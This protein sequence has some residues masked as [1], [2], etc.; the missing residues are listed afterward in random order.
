MATIEQLIAFAAEKHAGQKDKAGHPYIFHVLW[1][2][3]EMEGEEAQMIAVL[4]DVLED[5]DTTIL[6]LQR[7]GLSDCVIEAV[8]CLTRL[9]GQSYQDHIER[10]RSNPLARIVKLADLDD[11][12]ANTRCLTQEQIDRYTDARL[13]LALSIPR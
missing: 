12:L 11:H 3:L 7:L 13:L 2:M 10:C 6:D 9:K 1:V 5:T 8:K 4:H